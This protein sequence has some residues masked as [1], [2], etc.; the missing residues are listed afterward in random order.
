MGF[1]DSGSRGGFGGGRGGG[2][3]FGGGGRSFGG[4]RGGFNRD[5]PQRREMF[6]VTCTKCSKECQVPFKPT[7]SK[8][9][10]CSACFSDS[11]N[12]R[13]SSSNGSSE[14]FGQLSQINAK[15]DK[16][17]QVL[18]DL[19]LVI[20]EEASEGSADEDEEEFED[21]E[22]IPAETE[23]VIDSDSFAQDEEETI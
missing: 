20:D 22:E 4:D 1:R 6:D 8:P 9:V 2:R 7:G 15:L 14:S 3:S 11:G 23:V 5:R 13:S 18:Q 21:S 16:I 12:S 17:L 10:L 19:E